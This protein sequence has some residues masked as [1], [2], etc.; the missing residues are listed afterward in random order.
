MITDFASVVEV[1][2]HMCT[3]TAVAGK[4]LLKYVFSLEL[5]FDWGT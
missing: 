4:C 2:S 5:T 3:G 1:I